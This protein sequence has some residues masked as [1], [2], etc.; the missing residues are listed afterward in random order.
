MGYFKFKDKSIDEFRKEIFSHLGKEIELK[1]GVRWII[2]RVDPNDIHYVS[3]MTGVFEFQ[4]NGEF[5]WGK[6]TKVVKMFGFKVEFKSPPDNFGRT[7]H[8]TE[9]VLVP[10]EM[11]DNKHMIVESNTVNGIF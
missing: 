1:N 7:M 6:G 3:A 9:K 11:K 10:F 8:F 5:D 2:E 4:K